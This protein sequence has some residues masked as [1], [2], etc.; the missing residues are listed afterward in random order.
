M[1]AL[2]VTGVGR[3]GSVNVRRCPNRCVFTVNV[4]AHARESCKEKVEISKEKCR[5]GRDDLNRKKKVKISIE[6]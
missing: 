6:K 5:E 1:G 2:C 4:S 3:S